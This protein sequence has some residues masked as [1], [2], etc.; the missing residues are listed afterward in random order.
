MAAAQ[1]FL[2]RLCRASLSATRSALAIVLA[3]ALVAACATQPPT[4]A[5][6]AAFGDVAVEADPAPPSVAWTRPVT[7][8]AEGLGMGV[9]RGVSAVVV[10]PVYALAGVAA[11]GG[12]GGGEG[13]AIVG[14]GVIVVGAAIGAVWAPISVVGGVV[15]APDRETIDAAEPVLRKVLDDP[16]LWAQFA[17]RCAEAVRRHTRRD[18]VDR[19]RA[20]TVVEVRVVSVARGAA[21]NWWTFDRPFEVVVTAATR[22]VRRSDGIVLW[23]ETRESSRADVVHTYAE[24]AS[25]DGAAL[26]AEIDHALTDLAT[27]FAYT[28]FAEP[29]RD[30]FGRRAAATSEPSPAR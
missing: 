10:F 29:Q 9:V 4:A 13:A 15:T 19:S 21:W 24:W 2:R 17:P 1:P 12:G 14:A 28:I 8:W 27:G 6:R 25:D 18:L 26:R 16:S 23:E 20:K 22:V 5:D 7:G 30:R 3:P 11:A